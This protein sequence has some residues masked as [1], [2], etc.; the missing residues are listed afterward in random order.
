ML[1]LWAQLRPH[2]CAVWKTTKA[3]AA[4]TAVKL[5]VARREFVDPHVV[6]IW[7]KVVE[8]SGGERSSITRSAS[9]ILKNEATAQATMA[10]TA[11]VL[12]DKTT[13]LART[14]PSVTE[15]LTPEPTPSTTKQDYPSAPEPEAEPE[16]EAQHQEETA[17]ETPEPEQSVSS[18][19]GGASAATVTDTEP[20][21]SASSIAAASAGD[22]VGGKK[23]L[24]SL[25][26]EIH[27]SEDAA[28]PKPTLQAQE[29][30]LDDF[31]RDI[32]LEDDAPKPEPTPD[33]TATPE[34]QGSAEE[35]DPSIAL[36]RQREATIAKRADIVGR[37]QRW[38]A[39]LDELSASRERRVRETLVATRGD[40]VR[41][42]GGM[43]GAVRGEA[44]VEGEAG[45]LVR[46]LEGFL[47]KE[48]AGNGNG[49]SKGEKLGKWGKVVGKVEER[50]GE[51]VRG[52]QGEV[53]KWYMG[54]R[55]KEVQEVGFPLP[56]F[57]HYHID[58][59][60]LS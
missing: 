7:D 26:D 28:P 37:H 13:F 25:V 9:P 38:Q 31:L 15:S 19:V 20:M 2:L 36:A 33:A 24:E 8:L 55:E 17:P 16:P 56:A 23:A 52:V 18:V 51:K 5:G 11:S 3:Q 42:L 27:A 54:V 12:E 22:G 59:S 14:T 41:E 57:P 39:A 45:R 34:T 4:A 47:R 53:H 35:E 46:G 1:N 30:E 48:S 29:E 50:F 44:G 32:G 40:A 6:R 10:S 58:P 43:E 21:E 49:E 60:C